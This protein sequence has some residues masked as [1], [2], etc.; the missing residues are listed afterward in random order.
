MENRLVASWQQKWKKEGQLVGNG[1]IWKKKHRLYH[2]GGDGI[3][4][5]LDSEQNFEEK[6]TEFAVGLD[7]RCERK[8]G[9]TVT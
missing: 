7:L 8:K 4:K 3:V 6:L 1:D 9:V 2:G 5:W